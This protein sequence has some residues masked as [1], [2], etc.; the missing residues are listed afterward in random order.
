MLRATHP[1]PSR[2]PNAHELLELWAT[3]RRRIGRLRKYLRLRSRDEFFV[4]TVVRDC[5]SLLSY[6]YSYI[7][8]FNFGR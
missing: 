6:V 3:E 2:R 1:T 5:L 8:S 4:A 7:T